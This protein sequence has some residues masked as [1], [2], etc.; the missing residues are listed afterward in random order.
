M[1]SIEM[2]N[3]PKKRNIIKNLD[4]NINNI[5]KSISGNNYKYQKQYKN[6]ENKLNKI[7]KNKINLNPSQQ[8]YNTLK[9]S[10]DTDFI[11]NYIDFLDNLYV[12]IDSINPNEIYIKTKKQSFNNIYRVINSQLDHRPNITTEFTNFG[13]ISNVYKK[14]YNFKKYINP[15]ENNY[16]ER[17]KQLFKKLYEKD[18]KL[19]QEKIF[20][21]LDEIKNNVQKMKEYNKSIKDLYKKLNFSENSQISKNIDNFLKTTVKDL[22]NMKES[23]NKKPERKESAKNNQETKSVNIIELED[24]QNKK[25]ELLEKIRLQVKNIREKQIEQLFNI[26]DNVFNE[27]ITWANYSKD[28]MATKFVNLS[29]FSRA[30]GSLTPSEKAHGLGNLL[31]GSLEKLLSESFIQY[32]NDKDVKKL[33]DIFYKNQGNSSSKPYILQKNQISEINNLFEVFKLKFSSNPIIIQ[34]KL[35]KIIQQAYDTSTLKDTV[36]IGFSGIGRYDAIK[37]FLDKI[38]I[39]LGKIG[40]SY[41]LTNPKYN[42]LRTG[43]VNNNIK[44]YSNG[45]ITSL[46]D[47]SRLK[48]ILQLL[49]QVGFLLK[50]DIEYELTKSKLSETEETYLVNVQSA[51]QNIEDTILTYSMQKN[52]IR[53]IFSTVTSARIPNIYYALIK[54]RKPFENGR[55]LNISKTNQDIYFTD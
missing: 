14:L 55:S 20:S 2:T 21:I 13:S 8:N 51:F 12:K 32:I 31:M 4:K 33:L 27:K 9:I 28:L 54:G 30:I 35:Y 48:I 26:I 46:S 15:I 42:T 6:V 43:K 10:Q 40:V 37:N 17:Y 7:Y 45:H 49:I 1:Q 22:N 38:K 53:N 44:G 16:E 24:L 39:S 36:T 23:L 50:E 18:M 52:S 5:F 34:D 41:Q 47:S 11:E 19:K 29:F 25:K 3:I